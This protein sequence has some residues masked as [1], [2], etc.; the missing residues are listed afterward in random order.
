MRSSFFDRKRRLINRAVYKYEFEEWYE[1]MTDEGL[2][3]QQT[4]DGYQ[5]Y[6]GAYKISNTSIAERWNVS[7][8]SVRRLSL[9]IL[10]ADY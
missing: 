5:W 6:A 7:T 2:H 10:E 9:W 4:R 8:S 3:F 1:L